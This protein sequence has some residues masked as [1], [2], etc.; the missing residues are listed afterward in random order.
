MFEFHGWATIRD[1]AG[2]ADLQRDPSPATVE[3]I[4]AL[5]AEVA[6]TNRAVDVRWANGDVHVWFAGCHNHRRDEILTFFTAVADRAPGSYGVL[7]VHDDEDP[8]NSN[9]WTRF[10]MLRGN[11]QVEIDE[12]LSPHIGLVED[13]CPD[14]P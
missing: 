3:A 2:D 11:V 1:T 12:S 14:A 6:G 9:S 5:A 13:D 8:I 10:V 7:Y 4:Q